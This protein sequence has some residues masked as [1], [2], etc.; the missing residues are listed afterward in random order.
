MCKSITPR[1]N[2]NDVL[3]L[4]ALHP[5]ANGVL[6][7]RRQILSPGPAPTCV[8]VEVLYL[9]PEAIF[10]TIATHVDKCRMVYGGWSRYWLCFY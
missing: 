4:N 10:R 7:V 3:I 5:E 8:D 2:S 9:L 6:C 1:R